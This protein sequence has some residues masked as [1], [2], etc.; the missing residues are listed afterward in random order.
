MQRLVLCRV[1]LRELIS[2]A[3]DRPTSTCR[4]G[5][6]FNCIGFSES[7]RLLQVDI[8]ASGGCRKTKKTTDVSR[9][10]KISQKTCRKPQ[11]GVRLRKSVPLIRHY[12]AGSLFTG[13]FAI[14][15]ARLSKCCKLPVG[16]ALCL[17]QNR[18]SGGRIWMASAHGRANISR[19]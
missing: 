7:L 10:L 4:F 15:C 12:L 1:R 8:Q 6:N 11:I 14:G 17:W 3:G 16:A 9:K 5:L 19:H 18:K 2:L 13:S